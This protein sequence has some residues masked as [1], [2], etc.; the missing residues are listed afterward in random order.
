VK[1][2]ESL[3]SA[4]LLGV[5]SM[6]DLVAEFGDG[7][8]LRAKLVAD[9][10]AAEGDIAQAIAQSAGIP[11]V[12][13]T[14]ETLTPEVVGM[15]PAA[16]CRRYQLIPVRQTRRRLVV[17]MVDP[18]NLIAVDDVT[19]ATGLP[20]SPVAVAAD[21]LEMAFGRYLRLDEELNELSVQMDENSGADSAAPS[22]ESLESTPDDAPVVR[23]VS[24]L[25]SQAIDDRASDIHIE[26]GERYLTVRYRIDGVLHE[27]QQ[28]S[29]SIQD[30]VISR[31]KIMAAV[32][33]SE[34]RKPQDGR[35][36]VHHGGRKV[37][38][39]LATLPT[40]WGEKIVMR[41]LDSPAAELS[42]KDLRFSP[43]NEQSFTRAITK[44]YG[45]V[46]A[47]GPTGSGKSTTLYTA[48]SAIATPQV[49]AI[50]VEDPVEYRVPGISQV[51]VNPRAGLTFH[52]A[53]RSILRSDPDIVLVGEIRDQETATMS[54][55][56]A[57]TGHL[58]LSTLHTNDAPS[59][60]T[61][62]TNIG[63]EPFLVG[64]AINAVVAQRLARRLCL[65]CREA[66]VE[67]PERLDALKI[68]YDPSRP[69]TFYRS[70]GCPECS[71]TGFR[72]RV[73]LHEVMTMTEELEH[74][75][76]AQA[77]G[78]EM[79]AAAL[80]AGMVTLREDGFE[81]ARQGLTTIAEILRVSA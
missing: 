45:M 8:R 77:T 5:E 54:I 4:G 16:L 52:T 6:R 37:D 12:D 39:R 10:L 43:G 22:S 56:A 38:L 15:I 49:N 9:G 7:P 69:A 58:V 59:A 65:K 40:V 68:A 72:S 23:F 44:P 55:E 79:R 51:Q 48:L 17:G 26:P 71:G 29:R 62:L 76:T 41:I 2:A 70:T 61:R 46:L 57:L 78:T 42:L 20:V 31:L 28:A 50:T 13:L 80:R 53:L 81:K 74:L 24:L 36:S 3:V 60:L 47:T 34:R 1:I 25:I 19:T 66:Y 30:G 64:T 14:R 18:S 33:I 21:A 67:S 32:D 73:A 63:C 35:L 27:T 11:Y 75:V